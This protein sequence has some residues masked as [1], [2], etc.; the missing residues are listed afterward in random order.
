MAGA[1]NAIPASPGTPVLQRKCC[2]D[3]GSY[4][5]ASDKRLRTGI[6]NVEAREGIGY[7][8]S[9]LTVSAYELLSRH[10]S[11]R[12]SCICRVSYSAPLIHENCVILKVLHRSKST[13]YMKSP[14]GKY[15][16]VSPRGAVLSHCDVTEYAGFVLGVMLSTRKALLINSSSDESEK[17]WTALFTQPRTIIRG[18]GIKHCHERPPP[19]I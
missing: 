11:E 10:S 12:N 4:G 5:A 18:N 7:T 15:G 19:L 17:C 8:S 1:A 3:A 13:C 16:G 6:R 14:N 2:T 9:R